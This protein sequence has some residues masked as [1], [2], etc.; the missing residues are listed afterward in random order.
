MVMLEPED[1]W[2]GLSRGRPPS[3]TLDG[4]TSG[5]RSIRYE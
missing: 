5:R 3:T 2:L 4:S 1:L